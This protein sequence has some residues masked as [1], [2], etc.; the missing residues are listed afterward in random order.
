MDDLSHLNPASFWRTLDGRGWCRPCGV[1]GRRLSFAAI[2]SSI[3]DLQDDP[4]RS[5]AGALR[6]KGGFAKNKA[7][8]SEFLWADYLREHIDPSLVAQD[9]DRALAAAVELAL[10][11]S[12]A[13]Q[14]PTSG[15]RSASHMQAV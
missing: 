13:S 2:P 6:R 15:A 8:F 14:M 9:F 12:P 3:A 4:F 10:R 7:L 11:R 5:L 1:D